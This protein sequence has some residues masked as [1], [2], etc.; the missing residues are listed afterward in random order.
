MKSIMLALSLMIPA[1]VVYADDLDSQIASV[2]VRQVQEA[3]FYSGGIGAKTCPDNVSGFYQAGP[4][5]EAELIVDQIIN[6]GKK[7]WNVIDAG[8]PVVNLQYD[9]ATAL[10]KGAKCWLDLQQWEAPKSAAFV[11]SYKNIYGVELVYLKYRVLYLAGGNA[12]GVGKY[13]GYAAVQPADVR[14]SWGY[15]LDVKAAATAIYNQGTEKS[16]VGGLQLQITWNLKSVFQNFTQTQVYS[17][18][19]LGQLKALN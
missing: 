6:I 11:V 12:R 1:T 2:E 7:V 9:V 19:G 18:N 10:P 15:S 14:V 3:P 17:I 13:V 5:D 8:K 16:P 4:I